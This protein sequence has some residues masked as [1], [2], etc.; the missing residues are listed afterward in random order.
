MIDLDSMECTTREAIEAACLLENQSRFD[1]AI[2][3]PFL[4]EPSFSLVG[5]LGEDLGTDSILNGTFN[6]HSILPEM[7]ELH[8]ALHTCCIDTDQPFPQ[9][10]TD[11]RQLSLHLVLSL[12]MHFIFIKV[13]NC[14]NSYYGH[15]RIRLN[16][17]VRFYQ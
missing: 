4:E 5:N 6:I 12:R 15:V 7:K 1:Q 10:T 8:T 3:T 16:N 2:N 14:K 11:S 9:F 13:C 17:H